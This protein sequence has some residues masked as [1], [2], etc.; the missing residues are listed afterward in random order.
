[1]KAADLPDGSV[2][3]SAFIAHI[4]DSL[5]GWPWRSTLNERSSDAEVQYWLDNGTATALRVGAG[6]DTAGWQWGARARYAS[7]AQNVFRQRDRT[8]AQ[9]D[10]DNLT[11]H[12][13]DAVTHIDL[14]RRWRAVGDW[15]VVGEL[16]TEAGD[17]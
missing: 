4:K 17:G 1:M 16:E 5:P 10:V 9:A 12:H 11:A 3:A 13:S 14:V 15:Q 2:V 8:A 7:G 6:T